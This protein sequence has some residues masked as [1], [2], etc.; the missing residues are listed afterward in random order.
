MKHKWYHIFHPINVCDES[1]RVYTIDV[2][3]DTYCIHAMSCFY[4]NKFNYKIT[5]CEGTKVT[6]YETGWL[7]ISELWNYFTENN[8]SKEVLT[9]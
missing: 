3:D 7:T 6:D 9:K 8:I 1:S 4:C 5:K 2:C